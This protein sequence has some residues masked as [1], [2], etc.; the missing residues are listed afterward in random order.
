MPTS[1]RQLHGRVVRSTVRMKTSPQK[2]WEAWADPQQIANWFVDR[3]SGEARPGGTMKWFFDT[4]GYAMDVPIVEAEPGRAFVSGSG[5][6]P[7]PDGLP[8]LLEI[9]IE[10]DGSETVMHLVN[11]GFSEAPEKDDNFRGVESGWL[12]A[13]ATMKRWLERY[14]LLTRRHELVVRPAAYDWQ[15]LRPLFAT[16]D[17]RARWLE[18]DIPASG[19]VVC[20]TG[21]EV[22]IAWDAANSVIGLKAFSMGPQQMVALDASCWA[23]DGE[24]PVTDAKARMTRALD[25]L[26]SLL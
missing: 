14:P 16:P 25:R 8:Y 15:A 23:A 17:G 7:G 13:L 1:T 5:S 11:S 4:F 10:R 2:A 24:E 18:P 12:M 21:R 19:H 9:T 3:A 6:H 22:L 20:D 26:V